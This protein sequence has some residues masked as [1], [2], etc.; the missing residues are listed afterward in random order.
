MGGGLFLV[1][2]FDLAGLWLP[3]PFRQIRRGI[4]VSTNRLLQCVL[5]LTVAAASAAD[6][7]KLTFKFTNANV[8]GASDTFVSEINNQGVMVGQYQDKKGALHGYILNGKK[9]TTLDDPNGTN[10]GATGINFNGAIAV[11]GSYMNSSGSSVGFRY[12]PKTKKFTDIPSPEGSISSY[13]GGMN[14]RGWIV[15]SYQDSNGISHGFLLRGKKYT[16]LDVPTAIGSQ[17]YGIN[18]A[19]NITLTWLNSRGTYEGALYNGKTYKIINVPGAGHRGSEA[20]YI[21]N[22]G[23]ITFWW[24]DSNGLI[25]G[26]LRHGGASYKFLY[27]KAVETYPNGVNDRNTFVGQYQDAVNGPVS[28]FKATFK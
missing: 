19:G 25:H 21:N 26:A 6:A 22:E 15:G 16:T 2:L 5:G 12:A 23:D 11:V 4:S 28:S 20:S 14:D 1:H 10:T 24:F 9:L 27:P 13:L 7:P 3:K 8:P 18:N 17:A